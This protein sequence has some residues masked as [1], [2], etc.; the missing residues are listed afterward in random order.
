MKGREKKPQ[1]RVLPGSQVLAPDGAINESLRRMQP[2]LGLLSFMKLL[3][4]F[5]RRSS[6]FFQ[7]MQWMG[8]SLAT[9][10]VFT[11]SQLSLPSY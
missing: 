10:T 11:C 9:I 7:A 8:L 5:L 1:Q 6:P 3:I 2:H 4:Q